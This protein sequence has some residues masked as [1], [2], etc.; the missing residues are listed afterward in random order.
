MEEKCICPLCG[1][2]A[3][4]EV[5]KEC[6]IFNCLNCYEFEMNT[7]ENEP[8]LTEEEK[9]TLS[10]YFSNVPQFDSFRKII[11]TRDNYKDLISKMRN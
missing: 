10:N 7:F 6:T 11:I 2:D 1:N 3:R 9:L 8:L 4:K 5:H